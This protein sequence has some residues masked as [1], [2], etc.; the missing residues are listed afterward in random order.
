MAPVSFFLIQTLYRGKKKRA[1]DIAPVNLYVAGG[2][3]SNFLLPAPAAEHKRL[4]SA[5]A[6]RLGNHAGVREG[7]DAV[8]HDG[9]RDATAHAVE[10]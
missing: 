2:A 1:R 3:R 10:T 8:E 5:T 6:A 4:R 7:V 9:L